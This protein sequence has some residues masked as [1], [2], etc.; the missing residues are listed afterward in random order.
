MWI[1]C[2]SKIYTF[3]GNYKKAK[4]FINQHSNSDTILNETINILKVSC[5]WEGILNLIESHISSDNF[6]GFYIKNYYFALK[7]LIEQIS[8]NDRSNICDTFMKRYLFIFN[9]MRKKDESVDNRSLYVAYVLLLKLKYKFNIEFER[10]LNIVSINILFNYFS[11]YADKACFFKTIC[12]FVYIPEINYILRRKSLYIMD[13]FPVWNCADFNVIRLCRYYSNFNNNKMNK[14]KELKNNLFRLDENINHTIL[15]Y[16]K[17]L[18]QHMYNISRMTFV[19]LVDLF[20]EQ[21]SNDYLMDAFYLISTMINLNVSCYLENLAYVVLCK[22]LGAFGLAYTSLEKLH[23]KTFVF[24]SVG[25]SLYGISFY[26]GDRESFINFSNT[27]LDQYAN[28]AN[29]TSDCMYTSLGTQSYQQVEDAHNCHSR[30]NKNVHILLIKIESVIESMLYDVNSIKTFF[31]VFDS[32]SESIDEFVANDLSCFECSCD[33]SVLFDIFETFNFDNI[34][35][36]MMKNLENYWT[37]FRMT[38]ILSFSCVYHE[39]NSKNEKFSYPKPNIDCLAVPRKVYADFLKQCN[40]ISHF[41]KYSEK[42]FS[43]DDLLNE[44]DVELNISKNYYDIDLNCKQVEIIQEDNELMNN[45]NPLKKNASI[46]IKPLLS[47]TPKNEFNET[48]NVTKYVKIGLKSILYKNIPFEID[49]SLLDGINK[50]RS[51]PESTIHSVP[52]NT[53]FNNLIFLNENFSVLTESIEKISLSKLD[54][55][56]YKEKLINLTQE[57]IEKKNIYYMNG[58]NYLHLRN[59]EEIK[60]NKKIL[61]KFDA[62]KRISFNQ[63]TS[64]NTNAH[65]GLENYHKIMILMEIITF[66]FSNISKNQSKLPLSPIAHKCSIFFECGIAIG[67]H[68]C[69]LL[70][71]HLYKFFKNQTNEQQLFS[72]INSFSDYLINLKLGSSI[73]EISCFAEFYGVIYLYSTILNHILLVNKATLTD[74]IIKTFTNYFNNVS[75]W[76]KNLRMVIDSMIKNVGK[77]VNK[78]FYITAYTENIMHQESLIS[79]QLDALSEIDSFLSTK[80]NHLNKLHMNLSKKFA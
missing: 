72:S 61:K 20:L 28:Y 39:Y 78:T 14:V 60:T 58:Y 63:D 35:H 59:Y 18:R 67:V 6:N 5:H 68:N 31:S 48:S 51:L 52:D 21:E 36:I 40:D 53:V 15:N 26:V 73:V 75:M 32:H 17:S 44:K 69:A 54:D 7:K 4:Y 41:N 16:D 38:L 79:S 25:Y 27:A 30:L 46:L 23:T 29:E 33:H 55:S 47:E 3:I 1:S 13:T 45:T 57:S 49:T 66:G 56:K 8:V 34:S 9:L 43:N 50:D 71:L 37:I 80:L 70:V 12:S 62:S 11:N 22:Y 10:E 19:I 65:T 24:D 77:T 74:G 2:L 76:G 64:N 42:F